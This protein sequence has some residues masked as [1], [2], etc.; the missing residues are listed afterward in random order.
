[1]NK[2]NLLSI[3][4]MGLAFLGLSSMAV[5]QDATMPTPSTSSSSGIDPNYLLMGAA[6]LQVVILLSLNSVMRLLGGS[7]KAWTD[8]AR[9]TTS[10]VL[11]LLLV[12][13]SLDAQAAP[14]P[15]Q[16]TSNQLF[17]VLVL[18]NVFLFILILAQVN[19]LRSVTRFL[20]GKPEDEVAAVGV[21][22]QSAESKLMQMLTRR[23]SIEKEQ[24]VLLHHDYD[25]IRELDN[26]LPP[27]WLWLFYGTIIWGVVYL[28]NVHV[29]GVWP[30]QKTEYEQEMAQAKADVA[31]YVAKLGA[32]VD[33][34]SVT[35]L[36]DASAIGTG[37]G[38][39]EANC[40]ACHGPA[41]E[42]KAGLGPNLTDGYWIHGGG[43][44]NVF[45]TIKY[46]V[47]EKG[48]IDWKS[49]LKAP[50]LQAVASYVL[51]LQGTNPANARE[52][53]GDLWKE[54]GPAASDSTTVAPADSSV[55]PADTTSVQP[56]LAQVN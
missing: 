3:A 13:S 46:G 50:E 40:I 8:R 45:K 5:A 12:T 24:D 49:Q 38:I 17:Y 27:W 23:V 39:Y 10:A 36:T 31:A 26:A 53:Q 15:T 16:W 37:K 34:N 47:K 25:G 4:C 28:V 18:V 56:K 32:S 20:V 2:R 33:E 48:M 30:D 19:L 9:R 6:L 35:L 44:K 52:P 22:R 11:V 41:A 42:G 14:G 51:S 29:T 55:T 43:I 54:E 1:M 7:G 21:K